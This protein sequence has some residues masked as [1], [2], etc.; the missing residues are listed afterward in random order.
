MRSTFVQGIVHPS[1]QLFFDKTTRLITGPKKA[2]LMNQKKS[3]VRK[4]AF[5]KFS[6][7]PIRV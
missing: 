6:I 5:N 3:Y 4:T 1:T 7:T 2:L